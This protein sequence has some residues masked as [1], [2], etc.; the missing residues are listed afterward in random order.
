[1]ADKQKEKKERKGR[2][3]DRF[4]E[5]APTYEKG[6]LWKR[7]FVPLQ[8]QFTENLP[9]VKGMQVLDVGCG[10]GALARRLAEGGARVTGV[11][12][13]EGMLAEAKMKAEGLTGLDF[14]LGGAETMPLD[15]ASIDMAVTSVAIHHFEDTEKALK[16]I[17]RVLKPGA[18]LYACDMCGEGL[19]GR[20]SLRYGRIVG[21]DYKYFSRQELAELLE[22]CGFT[23]QDV[24]LLRKIPP[25]M[26]IVAIK[27]E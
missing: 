1:M 12:A 18:G 10:T 2:P 13:S 7:F 23:V 8:G 16:E 27:P 6:I 17:L 4:D 14:I 9:A 19:L 20:A 24:S 22:R 11:D 3:A 15:D 21:T 26:L 25:V 5:W